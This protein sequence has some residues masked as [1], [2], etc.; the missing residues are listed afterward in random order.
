MTKKYFFPILTIVAVL[1][2]VCVR[3]AH[4]VVVNLLGNSGFEEPLGIGANWNNDANRGIT[5]VTGSAPEGNKFLRM[6]EPATTNAGPPA[7]VGAFT[8]QTL[9]GVK[10]GDIVAFNGLVRVNAMTLGEEA[11]LRLEFQNTLSSWSRH[12]K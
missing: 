7:F 5:V 12:R 4:A 6:S 8:F 3:P 2:L 1:G 9:F 10:E 11:Q